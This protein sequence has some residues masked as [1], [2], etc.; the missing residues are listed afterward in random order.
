MSKRMEL[1][2]ISEKPIFRIISQ[3]AGKRVIELDSYIESIGAYYERSI[4]TNCIANYIIFCSGYQWI[5]IC[6][7]AKALGFDIETRRNKLWK[8]SIW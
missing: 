6:I 3:K 8:T 2:V 4:V 5:L 7:K 1:D